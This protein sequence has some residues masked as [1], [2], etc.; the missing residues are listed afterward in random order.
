M[1]GGIHQ[2]IMRE[3]DPERLLDL[4]CGIAVRTGGFGMAWVGLKRAG[5]GGLEVV[6]HDGAHADTVALL[7]QM[8][9]ED[10]RACHFTGQALG[11]GVPAACNDIARDPRAEGWREAALERG[12]LAMVSLPLSVAG[13]VRGIFNLYAREAHVFDAEELGLLERLASDVGFALEAGEH[14]T[15]RRLAEARMR[16]SE[17]RYRELVDA[18]P[19]VV[20]RFDPAG[21][22]TFVS[23]AVEGLLGYRSEELLGCP[24]T[25]VLEEGEVDGARVSLERRLGG[26]LGRGP[27]TQEYALRRKDGARV[28]VE[29]KSAPLLDEAGQVVEIQL[30]ARDIT[31]RCRAEAQLRQ[32]DAILSVARLAA[33]Q[34]LR[35]PAWREAV[36]PVLAEVGRAA[37]VSRVYLFENHEDATGRVLTSQLYEWVADGIESQV[38]NAELQGLEVD[39]VAFG[40]WARAM[41]QREA[42]HGLVRDFPPGESAVLEPQGIRAVA[43]FP[44][45][46]GERWWGF[47]GFDE[48]RRDRE[49]LVSELDALQVLA[50]IL[51]SGIERGL[52]EESVRRSEVRLRE[53][54]ELAH[55]G[56]WE[57]DVA[58]R[59]LEWSEEVYRIFETAHDRSGGTAAAFRESVHPDDLE[60]VERA[61]EE[62]LRGDGRGEIEHRLVLADGHI[63]HVYE[64]WR[65]TFDAAGRPLRSVGTVQDVTERRR[66]EQQFLQAKKM[67][68]VGQLA[69][70]V[71]HDFNNLLTTVMMQLG[72]LEVSS[73]LDAEAREA[74]KEIGKASER[75]ANLTR[76]LL[77]FGRRSAV[78]MR[79]LDLHE[80][81]ADLR[82]MLQRLIGETIRLA[83]S[84]EPDLPRVFADRGMLEQVIVNLCV[85]ARD[86]M[87]N[88]GLIGVR[89]RLTEWDEAS[90]GLGLGRRPGRFACLSVCD[91]GCGMDKATLARIFEPFFTTK[92]VGRGTGLGLATVHG[93]VERHQGWIEVETAVGQGTTF[94]I[95]LPVHVGTGAV[96]APVAAAR[97]EVTAG[98]EGILL[99]EDDPAVRKS[100][101]RLLRRWGYRVFEAGDGH[102]ALRVWNQ[103][104]KSI[105]L[106][107]TDAVMPGGLGGVEL[108][109]RLLQ[110][111]P[112]LKVILSSGY[113]A[114]LEQRDVTGLPGVIFVPKPCP[115]GDL[116]LAVRMSLSGSQPGGE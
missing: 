83:V 43:A 52:A 19:D 9:R 62:S 81:L 115:A 69:G 53:A 32:R 64:R 100:L 33:D 71:A 96:E 51:G 36:A 106:L 49:W 77:L 75:A 1:I 112:G 111:R 98:N 10:E 105:D 14:E 57:L 90:A 59:R 65:T 88:G 85:N 47:L 4:A 38:A 103:R 28:V 48:C 114:A 3:R 35:A 72:L 54:Q 23:S 58:T 104:R 44:I 74:V 21:R 37:N 12:I 92:P 108:A 70:G 109:G 22:L 93:I 110:E 45:F 50:G 40:R 95:F 5:R 39:G 17:A 84:T 2:A 86:A 107:F 80:V 87:P 102:E 113:I 11:D 55:L 76:Q 60:K 66:L 91:T 46:A 79:V 116:A 78:Q 99:A 27:V 101:A 82:K 41:R 7:R 42:I 61:Y 29:T 67:D 73:S 63:K 26:G 25:V 16:E 20:M 8:F 97:H 89:G 18:L 68:A 94:W 15:A 6:A 56:S 30:T 13:G 34:F 31:E 24:F